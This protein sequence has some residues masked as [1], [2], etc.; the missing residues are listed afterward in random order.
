MVVHWKPVVT[1][2][3]FITDLDNTLVGDDDALLQLNDR[4]H[5]HRE[6]YGTKIVYA[7]GR[8][9]ILYDELRSEK[10][11]LTPDILV[12]SVG[13][14]ISHS[15]EGLDNT[16]TN[17]LQQG[18]DRDKIEAIASQFTELTPQPSSEQTDFK[19]S[20]FLDAAVADRVLPPLEAALLEQGLSV[21]VIYSGSQD[22]DILP[23]DAN[24]GSA[25][26]YLRHRLQFDSV[27]TV[28]CGDSGNDLAMF[29]TD[30][31]RGIIVGNAQPELLDWHHANPAPHRYLAK[32][33]CA[34]GILEG[35]QH[36]GF[37]PSK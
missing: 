23:K 34:G 4:L 19:V 10:P 3:L 22:V 30:A 7:T 20:F 26:Y 37:L 6:T 31:N 24:K 2:F 28:V 5:H 17:L 18:W 25:V 12:A 1:P 21:N 33:H 14:I 32:A 29:A 8:S 35:L 36:F 16:W 9:P 13:T 27:Q 11:L 15:D